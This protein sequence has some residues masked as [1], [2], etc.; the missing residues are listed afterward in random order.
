[1][2]KHFFLG[3]QIGH[4]RKNHIKFLKPPGGGGPGVPGHLAGVPAKNAL[5]GQLFYGE[6]QETP[7]TPASRPPFVPPGVPGTSARCPED[8]SLVYVPSSFLIPAEFQGGSRAYG[9]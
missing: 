8:V 3:E 1:M 2:D 5:F 7:G 9:L 6:Q 4:I